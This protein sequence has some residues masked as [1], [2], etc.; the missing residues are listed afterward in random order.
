MGRW[1]DLPLTSSFLSSISSS[2]SRGRDFSLDILKEVG[3][4]LPKVLV[5]KFTVGGVLLCGWV[6]GWVGGWVN[7]REEDEAVW[8]ERGAGCRDWVGG[9]VDGWMG[10][11][12]GDHA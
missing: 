5:S 11:W 6:G 9:W 4:P 8:F 2:S 7:W 12:V 1:V 10:G 3:P